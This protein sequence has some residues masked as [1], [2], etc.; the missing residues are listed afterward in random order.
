MAAANEELRLSAIAAVAAANGG[1]EA[2]PMG[3]TRPL[4]P[5]SASSEEKVRCATA[6]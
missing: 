2:P 1:A 3:V 5:A 6:P 4:G